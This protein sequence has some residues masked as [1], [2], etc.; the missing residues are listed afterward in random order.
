MFY[1]LQIAQKYVTVDIPYITKEPLKAL[2]FIQKQARPITNV[3]FVI[4]TAQALLASVITYFENKSVYTVNS[5]LLE[6]ESMIEN[7]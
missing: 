3:F 5:K 2:K 4:L 6:I 1:Q 7:S